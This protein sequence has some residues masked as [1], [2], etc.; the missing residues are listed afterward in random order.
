M[1]Y[2]MRINVLPQES[3]EKSYRLEFFKAAGFLTRCC[4]KA[5]QRFLRVGSIAKALRAPKGAIKIL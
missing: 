3:V 5:D 2:I 4:G 1:I